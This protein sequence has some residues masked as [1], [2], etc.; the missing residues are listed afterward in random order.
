[1][2]AISDE[3]ER[4]V[5]RT[6]I[7][8]LFAAASDTQAVV[9]AV[10]FRPKGL[11]VSGQA[12]VRADTATDRYLKAHS[13]SSGA[14]LASLPAG[15]IGYWS[16]VLSPDALKASLWLRSMVVSAGP[17]AKAV[18]QALDE[19]AA[20]KLQ[21]VL[22]EYNLPLSV[23]KIY[24]AQHPEKAAAAMCK[25]FE[26]LE[27]G[28]TFQSAP[29]QGKP[30]VKPN[31]RTYRGFR[32]SSVKIKW[33][34]DKML[35]GHAE[36][37]KQTEL[38]K[39]GLQRVLGKGTEVWF[40]TNGKTVVAVTAPDWSSAQGRLDQYLDGKNTLGQQPAYQEVRRE[41]PADATLVALFNLRRYV[42]E[43][44]AEFLQ[45]YFEEH[46]L[47]APV[48]AAAARTPNAGKRAYVGLAVQLQPEHGGFYFWLPG[49]AVEE[50]FRELGSP[51]FE[52]GAAADR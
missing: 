24:H 29:I 31:A 42:H 46:A 45:P 52:R 20:A 28:A 2:D 1:M 37:D 3:S 22:G 27:A 33:D 50:V 26:A 21:S 10:E 16:M 23:L 51:S 40:G 6:T 7:R 44:V 11:A 15:Q 13:V 30:E 17:E 34:F 14:D 36:S 32:L 48:A 19:L 9:L 39:A 49:A 12:E 4:G 25:V 43:V 47:R 18:Q 5:L 35:A 38:A 8:A 41:L